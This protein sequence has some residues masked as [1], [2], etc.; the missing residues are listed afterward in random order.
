MTAE[1]ALNSLFNIIYIYQ[2]FYY[3]TIS[4]SFHFVFG[5]FSLLQ[6]H[7]IFF[8]SSIHELKSSFKTVWNILSI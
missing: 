5:L 7:D 8:Q 4:F 1:I 6:N 3:Q 2:A